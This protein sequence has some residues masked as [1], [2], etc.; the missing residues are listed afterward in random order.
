MVDKLIEAKANV[1]AGSQEYGHTP[2]CMAA[3]QGN[4]GILRSLLDAKADLF[5]VNDDDSYAYNVMHFVCD[6]S[7]NYVDTMD[8]MP[9]TFA[10]N[11]TR[12]EI[13]RYLLARHHAFPCL[14]MPSSVT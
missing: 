2:L 1:N 10:S 11:E 8:T 7:S 14:V 4:M 12:L 3:M 6:V 13:S 5:S 9:R